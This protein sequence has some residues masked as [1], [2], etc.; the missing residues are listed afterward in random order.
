MKQVRRRVIWVVAALSMLCITSVV[1]WIWW[2]FDVDMQKLRDRA[3]QGSVWA[4]TACGSI[5]YQEAGVGVP[6][7]AVHGSGGGH[8]QGCTRSL[9][10]LRLGYLPA[11][12]TRA[13]WT[14]LRNWV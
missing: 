11:S 13:S 8:D 3:N 10:R 1:L 7:L 6:L 12:W 9:S 5:E 14:F 2:R 4:E